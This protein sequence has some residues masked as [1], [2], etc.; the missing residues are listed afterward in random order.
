M[1]SIA[2]VAVPHVVGTVTLLTF[3]FLI[4]AFVQNAYT[5]VQSEVVVSKLTETASHVSFNIVDLVSLCFL[6]D[7]DQ[8]LTKTVGLPPSI[9]DNLYTIEIVPFSDLV[10]GETIY[11]VR[12]YLTLSPS[13]YGQSELPWTTDSFFNIDVAASSV[14]GGAGTVIHCQKIGTNITMSFMRG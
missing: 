12:A 6:S 9:Y 3:L 8:N 11:I 5:N 10:M 14:S 13:T 7:A 2:S 1:C 4:G